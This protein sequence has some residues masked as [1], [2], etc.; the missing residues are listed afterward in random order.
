MNGNDKRF[1]PMENMNNLRSLGGYATAGGGVTNYHA[2]YRGDKTSGL[3]NGEIEKI[4]SL[5]ITRVIDLRA[6]S[7]CEARPSSLQAVGGLNYIRVPL[8]DGFLLPYIPKTMGEVY[9]QLLQESPA[10]FAQIGRLALATGGGCLFH[11][12][13]G[14]D[15]TGITAMLLLLLAGVA[16]Q[17]VAED[18]CLTA[19]YA[20]AHME[21][22][23]ELMRQ[24][25]IPEKAHMF[26]AQR[27]EIETALNFLYKEYTD[28]KNYLLKAGLSENEVAALQKKLL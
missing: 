13:S 7:E 18:Y 19:V 9:V 25:G 11:C 15:R 28:A 21:E 12:T 1:I 27:S 4:I 10:G 8:F 17:D 20:K 14:K 2:F 3:T 24:R 22:M 6:D 23:Q 16:P 5:G 26:G